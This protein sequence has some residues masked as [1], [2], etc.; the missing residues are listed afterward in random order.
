MA[1]PYDGI[2]NEKWAQHAL[3]CL[4]PMK[5]AVQKKTKLLKQHSLQLEEEAEH[6]P[7]WGETKGLSVSRLGDRP[8]D[9]YEAGGEA[10]LPLLFC[11]NDLYMMTQFKSWLN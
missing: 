6:V 10:N 3:Q 9:A 1:P 11:W 5:R 7:G 2:E 4:H 8:A